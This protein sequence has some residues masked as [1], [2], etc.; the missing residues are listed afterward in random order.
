MELREGAKPPLL[1]IGSF[2]LG[3]LCVSP[4][5]RGNGRIV[6]L[7]AGCLLHRAGYVQIPYAS[8][9]RQMELRRE[10]YHEAF[11][12]SLK[13]I[14]ASE[15]DLGP[16]LDYYLQVVE[17]H[18]EEIE[19]KIALERPVDDYPP[20]Q[21]RILETVR[22]HGHVDAALLIQSTGANRN[23]LKDNLRR[24]VRGGVLEKTGERRGTRYRLSRGMRQHPALGQ[25]LEH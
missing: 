9:E 20:L 23:T 4:F 25:A 12:L 15:A 14:W 16:W 21:R 22:E 3:L 11:A 24:L 6:R 13:R 18:R 10:L 7:L 1:V 8:L 19:N 5:D 2:L 17:A